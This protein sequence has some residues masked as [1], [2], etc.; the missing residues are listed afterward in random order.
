MTRMLIT[1]VI[2]VFCLGCGAHRKQAVVHTSYKVQEDFPRT[3]KQ[4]KLVVEVFDEIDKVRSKM[5]ED[6][7]ESELA[8]E[9]AVRVLFTVAKRTIL[10]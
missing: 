3:V 7:D 8:T 4:K 1:V 9:I 2:C 5:D 10:K 6:F